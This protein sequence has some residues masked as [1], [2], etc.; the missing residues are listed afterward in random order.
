MMYLTCD[1]VMPGR[2]FSNIFEVTTLPCWISILKGLIFGTAEPH[3]V[4]ITIENKI[5]KRIWM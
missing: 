1:L 2:S 4:R 5:K 3:A